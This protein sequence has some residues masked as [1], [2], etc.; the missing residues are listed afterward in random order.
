MPVIAVENK[1][2]D[3]IYLNCKDLKSWFGMLGRIARLIGADAMACCHDSALS[4]SERTFT[5]S[6]D[7]LPDETAFEQVME[8]A[9][10]LAGLSIRCMPL[11][12]AEGQGGYWL[13]L[14][15]EQGETGAVFILH[16]E[17]A[18]FTQREAD[19]LVH[20]A[21]HLFRAVRLK[22]QFSR[23]ISEAKKALALLDLLQTPIFLIDARF[24]VV[25]SNAAARDLERRGV[26]TL[27]RQRLGFHSQETMKR[28]Q[29]VILGTGKGESVSEQDRLIRFEQPGGGSLLAVVEPLDGLFPGED[30]AP[31]DAVAAIFLKDPERPVRSIEA[32]M[33]EM[34]GMP[35]AEA[36]LAAAI[37][38]GRTIKEY[39]AE[40]DLSEGYVRDLSKRA[41]QRM[42][43][44]SQHQLVRAILQ[45]LPEI[46]G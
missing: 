21:S 32:V 27:N 43:V 36:R 40:A 30:S 14:H 41:M 2:L 39:A 7:A 6:G 45:T 13:V 9:G 23:M 15:D 26:V 35:P 10:P 38:D 4:T 34:Y 20:L 37:A 11:D 25:L 19:H 16:R 42:G 1:T 8:R 44:K 22:H 31:D 5:V 28:A 24:S 29:H 46:G 18:A 33:R 17:N 3:T 12:P